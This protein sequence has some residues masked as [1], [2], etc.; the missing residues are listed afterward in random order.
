MIVGPVSVLMVDRVGVV[1]GHQLPNDAGGFELH[2][3]NRPVQIPVSVGRVQ[4]GTASVLAVPAFSQSS[5]RVLPSFEVRHGPFA[6]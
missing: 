2:A 5:G 4:G 6:P 3:V 1:P